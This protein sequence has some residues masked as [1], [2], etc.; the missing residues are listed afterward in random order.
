MHCSIWQCGLWHTS[1]VLGL[2]QVCCWPCFL[3]AHPWC[4]WLRLIV[5][6]ILLVSVCGFLSTTCCSQCH[7]L[8][9]L[10]W[11]CSRVARVHLPWCCSRAGSMVL[12]AGLSCEQGHVALACEGG[13]TCHVPLLLA[14]DWHVMCLACHLPLF[15][16]GPTCVLDISRWSM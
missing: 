16:S 15:Y 1:G 14:D 4:E 5:V 8:V 12:L 3:C 13:L 10:A 11:C 6:R 9:H 2:A 7:R